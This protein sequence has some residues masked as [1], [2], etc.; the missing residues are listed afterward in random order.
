MAENHVLLETIQLSQTATSV[1]FDNIPQ[2]GYTDLKVLVSARM[3]NST[4]VVDDILLSLNGS[5]A[6]FTMRRFFAAGTGT[7]S[8]DGGGGNSNWLG[9]APN[10]GSTADVYGNLEFYIPGYASSNL[11]NISVGSASENAATA[12][13]VMMTSL[14]WSN[15]AAITSMTLSGYSSNFLSGSTF[16]LYGIAASGTNPTVAPFA[17]GGNIVANDGTYW[18]HA[19]L[20]SGAFIPTKALTCDYLVIAGGGAGGSSPN[21]EHGGGGG[22]AGGYLSSVGSS[23]GGASAGSVLSLTAQSYAVSVGAGGTTNANGTNTTFAGL[24]ATGGGRGGLSGTGAGVTGG[25]GGGGSSSSSPGA[26]GAATASPVQGFAGGAG[27]GTNNYACGGG[28]GAGAVGKNGADAIRSD[29]G[30]GK[31][32]LSAWAT[33]TNTGVGGYYAGGGAGGFGQFGAFNGTGDGKGG[34]GGGGN[35]SSYTNSVAATAGVA[36]TGSGGGGSKESG[37]FTNSAVG[38]NGGSGIVIV[39]YAMV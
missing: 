25:S 8:A 22:G 23:G 7:P 6:S 34:L 24:T 30:V 2:T 18:Y 31:N 37:A 17:S 39:R 29:G 13:Y 19:F 15:T 36:N 3:S 14:L 28:G 38:G 9:I 12:A 10:A 11:K 1:T 26:G 27:Q 35:G 20:S 33:A 16:S 4:N 32:T 21:G 5:T